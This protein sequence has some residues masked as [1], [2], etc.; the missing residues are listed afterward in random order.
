MPKTLIL[1]AHTQA[2]GSRGG[3][4]EDK[5]YKLSKVGIKQAREVGRLLKA[6]TCTPQQAVCSTALRAKQTLE[7]IRQEIDIANKNISF[8]NMLYLCATTYK[9]QPGLSE[10]LFR[11]II[12][13]KAK[14]IDDLMIVGHAWTIGGF[15]ADRIVFRLNERDFSRYMTAVED[16]HYRGGKVIILS[17]K[18]SSWEGVFDEKKEKAIKLEEVWVPEKEG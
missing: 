14:A 16:Y 2:Q 12:C 17:A 5:Y 6:K 9:A 15:M 4:L 3:V 11:K 10:A 8:N 18:A 13:P 7:F 1:I